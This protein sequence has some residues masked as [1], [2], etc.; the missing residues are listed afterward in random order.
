MSKH[1]NTFQQFAQALVSAL[2]SDIAAFY[3]MPIDRV[4]WLDGKRLTAKPSEPGVNVILWHQRTAEGKTGTLV[5]R[6]LLAKFTKGDI[7]KSSIMPWLADTH[8][9]SAVDGSWSRL[10]SM[11]PGVTCIPGTHQAAEGVDKE[12]MTRKLEK[13]CKDQGLKDGKKAIKGLHK[14][15]AALVGGGDLE[16]ATLL[17]FLGFVI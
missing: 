3:T 12:A 7:A 14:S 5:K 15:A 11:R 13:L 16:T 2:T 4:G 8:G 17:W 10:V 6:S 9:E 1:N